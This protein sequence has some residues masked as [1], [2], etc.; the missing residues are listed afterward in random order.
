MVVLSECAKCLRT[1]IG[2]YVSV[3]VHV[4]VQFFF[5]EFERDL[6]TA[7]INSHE[8]LLRLLSLCFIDTRLISVVFLHC[9]QNLKWDREN[10]LNTQKVSPATCRGDSSVLA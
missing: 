5:S 8:L 1:H 3:C 7:Y 4:C 10:C 9:S 6:K 2:A